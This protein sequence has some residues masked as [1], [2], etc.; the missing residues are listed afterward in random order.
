MIV[1]F[2]FNREKSSDIEYSELISSKNIKY[3]P[4]APDSLKHNSHSDQK[5]SILAIKAR[6][7]RIGEEQLA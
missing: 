2:C 3:E 5:E 6:A 1:F 4:S 7:I